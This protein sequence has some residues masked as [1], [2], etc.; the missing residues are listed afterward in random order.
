MAVDSGFPPAA[1]DESVQPPFSFSALST[2]SVLKKKQ[3]YRCLDE[4]SFFHEFKLQTKICSGFDRFY[5]LP[6]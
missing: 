4:Y 2:N 1:P 6:R 5:G 3:I